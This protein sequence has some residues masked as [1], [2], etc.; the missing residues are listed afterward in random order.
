[1]AAA[2]DT[3]ITSNRQYAD[4]NIPQQGPLNDA[5]PLTTPQV[6]YGELVSNY[7]IVGAKGEPREYDGDGAQKVTYHGKG[8]ISL[9]SPLTKLAFTL[10]YKQT[11]FLLNDAVG[12]PGARVMINR[13]PRQR[14]EKVA[15]F[16]KVDGD[17][18]PI[19]ANGRIVWMVDGYTTMSNYPYSERNSLSDLTSSS[20]TQTNRTNGQPSSQINYIRNSV[21]A[22]VDAYDGTVTLY[23]WDDQDPVLK[24]WMNIFPGLVKPKS[25]MPDDILS[26]V[27]YPEDLFEAQRKILEQYHVDNP[28]TFYNVGDKWTVPADPAPLAV[29][30]QPPYYVMADPQDASTATQEFQL[31]SPMKVN[32]KT[33]LAAYISVDCDPDHYGQMTVLRLGSGSVINGPEQVANTF[34][35]TPIVSSNLTLFDSHGSTVRYG[36]LLTLPVGKSFL[37]VEPLYVQASSNGFPILR[38]VL[39]QYGGSDN[40]GYGATLKD[41]LDDLRLQRQAGSTLGSSGTGG[42]ENNNQTQAPTSPS[43]SNSSTSGPPSSSPPALPTTVNGVLTKLDDVNAK[44]DAARSSSPPDLVKIAQLQEQEQ[45]LVQQLLKLNPPSPSPTPGPS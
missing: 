45:K 22:T 33:N 19:V 16:L 9:S 29:G 20:L 31:T 30:N 41:A 34:Y 26:H 36:N 17:P 4:G 18:Y 5:V 3:D 13:D 40:I 23:A 32:N 38:R 39:A 1:V 24:A 42:S 12:A 7:A 11:N 44:L 27:R 6:Y 2:A 21:K 43:T 10:K 28:V 25:S 35:S 14:V 15:P 8:G 37:Y